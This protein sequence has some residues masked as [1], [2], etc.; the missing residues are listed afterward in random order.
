MMDDLQ[1]SPSI[2]QSARAVDLVAAATLHEIV[3]ERGDA[4]TLRR[5]VC[6][7]CRKFR[8]A[9][10]EDLG[11]F[12]DGTSINPQDTHRVA[13]LADLRN[14]EVSVKLEFARAQPIHL[15]SGR[16]G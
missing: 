3:A 8:V 12:V 4:A 6:M 16:V 10:I 14:L 2:T 13:T 11:F 9:K 7:L 1:F 15:F 5:V